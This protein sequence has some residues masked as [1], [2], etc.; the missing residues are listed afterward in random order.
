VVWVEDSLWKKWIRVLVQTTA[1]KWQDGLDGD[2][3]IVCLC[4][5]VIRLITALKLANAMPIELF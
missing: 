3:V 2:D 5:G 1:R 4:V